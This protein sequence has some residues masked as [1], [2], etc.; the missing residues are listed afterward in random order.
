[1]DRFQKL[2]QVNRLLTIAHELLHDNDEK[3]L[4]DQVVDVMD[5]VN[6]VL[7]D[8]EREAAALDN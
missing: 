3:A 2:E 4:A 5:E 7:Y 6:E 8:L 1:M